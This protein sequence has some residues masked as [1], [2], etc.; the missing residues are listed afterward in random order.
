MNNKYQCSIFKTGYVTVQKSPNLRRTFRNSERK[1]SILKAVA[2]PKNAT[3]FQI[4]TEENPIPSLVFREVMK[5]VHHE[6][7]QK[8]L[9]FIK[10]ALFTYKSV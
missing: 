10:N 1:T 9:L 6:K 4:E 5:L 2:R 7:I 3:V 8:I